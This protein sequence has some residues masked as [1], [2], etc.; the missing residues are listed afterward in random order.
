MRKIDESIR[1]K[2]SYF[3]DDTLRTIGLFAR[4]TS[5]A[6][7]EPKIGTGPNTVKPDRPHFRRRAD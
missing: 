1:H 4:A 6:E 3:T 2:R 5:D 7:P